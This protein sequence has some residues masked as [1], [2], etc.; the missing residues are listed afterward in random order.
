[1]G[2]WVKK[3]TLI[4]FG[5]ASVW[6]LGHDHGLPVFGWNE[7]PLGLVTRSQLAEQD[8]TPGRADVVAILR[9]HTRQWGLVDADLFWIDHAI[10]KPPDT[11]ARAAAR[12]KAE[13]VLRW[14]HSCQQEVDHRVRG[15]KRQCSTC[16]ALDKAAA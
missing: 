5:G 11:P 14:C 1:M 7:A 8:L 4:E 12:A 13:K 3:R 6:C 10:P 2:H 15:P 16:F 9:F